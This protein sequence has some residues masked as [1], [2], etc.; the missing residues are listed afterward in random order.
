MFIPAYTDYAFA[1]EFTCSHMGYREWILGFRTAEW[2]KA[3]P[4][5]RRLGSAVVTH[6]WV[7][8]AGTERNLFGKRLSLGHQSPH[9]AAL[10][11]DWHWP[12]FE[13]LSDSE[14]RSLY[15]AFQTS[16]RD[17]LSAL[18]GTVESRME[19]SWESRR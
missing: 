18:L 7:S 5:E 3:S 9:E 12:Y 14:L 13:S 17:Q 19:E 10:F 4:I 11:S 1:C 6:R 8:Y 15:E 2:H 16:D